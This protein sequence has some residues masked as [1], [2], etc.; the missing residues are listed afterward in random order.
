MFLV[1]HFEQSLH[2]KVKILM[3]FFGGGFSWVSFR[4]T[5][6]LLKGETDFDFDVISHICMSVFGLSTVTLSSKTV[7]VCVRNRRLLRKPL[8]F[9]DEPTVDTEA[10]YET[11]E[12]KMGDFIAELQQHA[13]TLLSTICESDTC[14]VFI[15]RITL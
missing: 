8:F 13:S 7:C 11:M 14:S 5:I 3:Y 12:G 1:R 10:L 9:A 6:H 15:R 4:I 2:L